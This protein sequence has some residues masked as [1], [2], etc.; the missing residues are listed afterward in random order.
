MTL[1]RDTHDAAKARHPDAGTEST[2]PH[3]GIALAIIC[4]AQL[5]VVLDA[6][7]VNVALPSIQRQLHF[8]SVNLEWVI[9]GYALAFGGLLLLGGRIGDLF[10]RRR[11]FITGVLLFTTASFLG[12][13]APDQG[14]L[15][16]ARFLQGIGG[17]IAAPTA[18]AL[19][20]S[21]FP[22][23][24]SR[25]R[26]MGVYA[27][28]SAGGGSL[29]LLLGGILTDIAS[30]RW[31]LFVNVPIGLLVAVAAPRFIGETQRQSGRLD[32]MG[33]LTVSVGM[34]S[35][36]YGLAHAASHEWASAG[37]IVPLVVAFCLL[38]TFIG[39]EARSGHAIM[40][41]H[42]F[43]DRNRSGAYV[44]ML[45]LAASLFSL[46]FY[47]TQFVQN[48]LGF[49]PIKAGLSFLPLT[50]GIALVSGV[51]AKFVGR[52]GTRLPMTLGP[53]IAAVALIWISRIS[54]HSTY[55]GAVLGPT[56]LIAV[57]LGLSFVPLTLTAISGVRNQEQ[58]LA[59]ALL[60]TGQQVGASLG[61]AILVTVATAVTRGQHHAAKAVAV[62]NGYAAAFRV[63]AVLAL[64][65]FA[66]AILSIRSSRGRTAEAPATVPRLSS[67]ELGA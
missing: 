20:A 40:P 62:T 67:E 2:N 19:I 47:L 29:G 22:E 59:S 8:S 3:L 13:L 14:W 28:M 30:W 6:T 48:I 58:G 7:V 42:I 46:F 50:L 56:I 33:A 9:T 12:G 41:L 52:V 24:P 10:G 21:T 1:T 16:G 32:L 18:L 64:L 27:A 11:M 23:G 61:L 51:V 4:A 53:L 25:N 65:A 15:I 55:T 63:G 49:S 17:A 26:A 57:A 39:I 54:A 35:L 34:T 36:V 37:T 43:T 5:M 45:A 31:V 60:N 38:T 66:V 44:I